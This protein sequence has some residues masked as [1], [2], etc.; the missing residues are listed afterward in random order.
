MDWHVL[1]VDDDTDAC[2][3]IEEYLNVLQVRGDRF[4]V[5]SIQDFGAALELIERQRFDLII[6]DVFR[7]P[8]GEAASSED[9]RRVLTELQKRQ[10]IP[11]VF[12]TALPSSVEDLR[13]RVIE[14]VAKDDGLKNL[15]ATITRYLEL[16]LLRL[17]RAFS[18]HVA[19][20]FRD[21]LWEFLPR[22]WDSIVEGQDATSLAYILC[23]RLAASLEGRGADT[24]A[25]A[26]RGEREVR[27]AEKAHPMQCYVIPPVDD[28]YRAGDIMQ[29]RADQTYWIIVSPSCDFVQHKAH[30]ALVCWCKPLVEFEEYQDWAQN[31]EDHGLRG[32]LEALLKNNPQRKQKD[33]YRFLPSAAS[34]PSLLVDMQRARAVLLH[35]LR[36]YDKIASLDAPFREDIVGQFSRFYSRIGSPDLDLDAVFDRLRT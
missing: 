27:K 8:A 2:R 29:K 36:D 10:F 11:V 34:L 17:N 7:G 5:T 25:S 26:I 15:E 1:V 24:L 32:R 23:R 35:E 28:G 31:P 20:V 30:Y 4:R 18:D 16:G 13:S 12:Y 19:K 14:I 33:R 6:L 22:H 9:G 3:Q 21:Y